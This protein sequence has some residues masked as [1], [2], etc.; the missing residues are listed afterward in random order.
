MDHAWMPRL[1][2]EYAFHGSLRL[3]GLTGRRLVQRV[4]P[5]W[6][7]DNA[8]DWRHL[9]VSIPMLLSINLAGISFSGDPSKPASRLSMHHS[10]TWRW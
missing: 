5:I 9:Q 2:S 8:A 6:T 1:K 7:G 4:G 10:S 3:V